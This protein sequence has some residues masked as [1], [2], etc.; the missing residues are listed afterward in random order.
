L[1]SIF[2]F[3]STF[4]PSS[5][6]VSEMPSGPILSSGRGASSSTGGAETRVVA[7][8]VV[9][10]AAAGSSFTTFSAF[11]SGDSLSVDADVALGA[12]V[13]SSAPTRCSS[14]SCSR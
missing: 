1:A 4:V 3:F 2:G 6:N 8:V 11:G 7:P 12:V 10:D 5:G 14:R 9:V 13:P